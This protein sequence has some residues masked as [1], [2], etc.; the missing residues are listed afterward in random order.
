M[1]YR[2]RNVRENI[3]YQLV[4]PGAD[5]LNTLY[6]LHNDVG[7][8]GRER[9]LDLVRSRFFWPS[10]TDSVR[11]YVK[12]CLSCIKRKSHLP[13][14][15]PLINVKTT[16]PL[17]LLCIDFLSLELCKGGIENILVI[18]D[19]FTRYVHAMLTKNQAAKTTALVLYD[20]FLQ[21]GF[22]RKLHSDQGRNFESSVIKE[23]RSL[24]GV[25]KC[26]T[27]LYHPMGNGTCER[28]N[29]TLLDMSG[30]LEDKQ[31][32]NWKQVAL[33]LSLPAM[34]PNMTQQVMHPL[35]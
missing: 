35:I 13:E 27:T 16:Q 24:F 15:A 3:E 9:T 5:R 12:K 8:L 26:R 6:G 17:E 23:L 7:H 30:T 29:N 14:R 20:F 28:F 10:M 31:K 18:T 2:K 21:Y 34:P 33:H 22:P 4:L 32:E 19:H 11:E 1:L 25:Q